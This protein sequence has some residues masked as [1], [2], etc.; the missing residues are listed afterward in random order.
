MPPNDFDDGDVTP[1]P[2]NLSA[3]LVE[4]E[5][6]LEGLARAVLRIHQQGVYLHRDFRAFREDCGKN[7][8]AVTKTRMSRPSNEVRKQ[9]NEAW[10]RWGK[11]IQVIVGMLTLLGMIG[12][13]WWWTAKTFAS[14]REGQAALKVQVVDVIGRQ[15]KQVAQAQRDTD[16]VLRKIASTQP[17]GD[18]DDPPAKAVPPRRRR[19]P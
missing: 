14:V 5:P 7:C 10:D 3:P 2:I 16:V 6:T 8:A 19:Q 4:V 18:T 15:V 1:P 17:D 12:G 9:S 13:A 11:R